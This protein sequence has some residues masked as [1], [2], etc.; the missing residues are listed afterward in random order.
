MDGVVALVEWLTQD[1]ERC[2]TFRNQDPAL[3]VTDL[4]EVVFLISGQPGPV[5]QEVQ[6][7]R[8]GSIAIDNDSCFD[9]ILLRNVTLGVECIHVGSEDVVWKQDQFRVTVEDGVD[10]TLMFRNILRIRDSVGVSDVIEGV[11]CSVGRPEEIINQFDIGERFGVIVRLLF[12]RSKVD[13]A[14][15]FVVSI[16]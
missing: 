4:N 14:F 2:L 7:I 13:M 9:F 11:T 10:L 1:H 3:G 12:D 16:T 5:E 8:D 6:L 15:F